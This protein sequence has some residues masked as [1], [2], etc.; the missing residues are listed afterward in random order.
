MRKLKWYKGQLLPNFD[1]TI[2]ILNKLKAVDNDTK[3][4][5]WKKTVIKN[6]SWSTQAVRS[7][8]GSNVLLGSA[9]IVQIPKD[10]RYQPYNQ[11]KENTA[12]F[13]VSVGDY[14]IK[15]EITE[16]VT[17]SNVLKIVNS[18]R[19]DAFQINFFR[20]NTGTVELAEHYRVEGV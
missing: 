1:Y 2:T 15:G 10:E 6:C 13:T 11:W 20:N 17:A 9:Y 3:L 7:V 8:S 19:P 18:H 4:D 16:D 5:V 14:I 12:G